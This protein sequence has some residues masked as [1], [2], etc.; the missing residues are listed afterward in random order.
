MGRRGRG[1]WRHG[2]G[3][4]QPGE[5]GDSPAGCFGVLHESACIAV[6]GLLFSCVIPLTSFSPLVLSPSRTC[7]L[8]VRARAVAVRYLLRPG[9]G[10]TVAA[11]RA[12]DVRSLLSITAQEL[13][14]SDAE[15]RVLPILPLN[16]QIAFFEKVREANYGANCW[17]C[18]WMGQNRTS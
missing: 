2:E 1:T 6:F 8:S 17:V 3:A 13:H 14:L 10:H 9:P 18:F 16:S 5:G 15:W 4:E 7:A 11:L 12:Y